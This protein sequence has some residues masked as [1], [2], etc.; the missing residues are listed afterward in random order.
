MNQRYDRS[1]GRTVLGLGILFVIVGLILMLA[2]RFHIHLG[3]LPGDIAWEGKRGSF[4]FPIVTCALLSILLTLG[5]WL[6]GKW[7]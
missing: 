6:L 4:Y 3:R 1:V 5:M 2:E 7:K